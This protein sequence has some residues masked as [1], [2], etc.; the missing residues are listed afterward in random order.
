YAISVPVPSY[1]FEGIS[2]QI[3]TLLL[4]ARDDVLKLGL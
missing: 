1:R 3:E 2:E 4:K